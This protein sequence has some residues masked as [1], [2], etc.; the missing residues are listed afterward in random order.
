[1]PESSFFGPLQA[2]TVAS[3][4]GPNRVLDVGGA[5]AVRVLVFEDV[6]QQGG[7]GIVE[8]AAVF[9]DEAG[10]GEQVA[11]VGDGRAGVAGGAFAGLG[12]VGAGG[13]LD[14]GGERGREAG[15]GRDQRVS[16][17]V[18]RISWFTGFG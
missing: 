1:M 18:G 17:R 3:T 13:V 15:V 7:G 14:G 8:V 6:V 16:F 9:Q 11:Q 4:V 2:C 5:G 10:D 12:G